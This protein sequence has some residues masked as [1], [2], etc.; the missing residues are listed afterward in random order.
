MRWVELPDLKMPVETGKLFVLSK[1]KPPIES[2]IKINFMATLNEI[3]LIVGLIASGLF[4][5]QY[6]KYEAEEEKE[7]IMNSFLNN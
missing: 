1:G 3:S 5:F 4:Y 2:F 7:E 6:K